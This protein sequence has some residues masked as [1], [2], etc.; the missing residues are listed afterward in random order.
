[1]S[2][3]P[4]FL[5]SIVILCIHAC[6]LLDNYLNDLFIHHFMV[7]SIEHTFLQKKCAAVLSAIPAKNCLLFLIN[8]TLQ[9]KAIVWVFRFT[10]LEMT[11]KNIDR[12]DSDWSHF[13]YIQYVR[14]VCRLSNATFLKKQCECQSQ[15]F[16]LRKFS[17]FPSVLCGF[18]S[19]YARDVDRIATSCAFAVVWLFLYVHLFGFR[20]EIIFSMKTDFAVRG[21]FPTCGTWNTVHNAMR[22]IF[23]LWTAFWSSHTLRQISALFGAP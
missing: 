17:R 15:M 10:L 1:M 14:M 18:E 16:S 23:L 3:W 21:T 6:D 13:I 12:G 8:K 22:A 20:S 4:T 2:S 7:T 19:C 5:I 9:V 11:V